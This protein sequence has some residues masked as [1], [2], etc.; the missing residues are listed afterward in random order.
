MQNRGESSDQPQQAPVWGDQPAQ[1]QQAYAPG[2]GAYYPGQDQGA[3]GYQQPPTVQMN[4]GAP[5]GPGAVPAAPAAKPRSKWKTPVIALVAFGIGIAIGAA[6]SGGSKSDSTAAGST[7]GGAPTAA[8]S[9]A[10]GAGA[11]VA[12]TS[13]KPAAPAT[14]VVLKVSGN[15][16]KDTKAFTTGDTWSL[17]YSYDCSSD[18][19][20]E[21]NFQVYEDY[22]SGDILVNAL[23]KKGSDVEYRTGDAGKHTLKMNSECSWSITVT[24]G[25]A[26]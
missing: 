23:A 6:A 17:K 16:I 9:H 14:H 15:G 10:A 3:G 7:S 26:G 4:P 2:P 8:A 18:G 11:P 22:P 21:G 5:L 19:L 20:D 24:D 13:T 12:K 25:D 1:P